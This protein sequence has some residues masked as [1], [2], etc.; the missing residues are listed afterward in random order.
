[1]QM[2]KVGGDVMYKNL[3][4][5]MNMEEITQR[6]MAEYLNVHENTIGNKISGESQFT[7]E[8]AFK[9]KEHFFPK[10][11]LQYLFKKF[12]TNKTK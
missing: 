3:Q 4:Q 10:Y 6:A 11:E 1:M 5:E 12:A 9:I 8:E 2:H 7:I